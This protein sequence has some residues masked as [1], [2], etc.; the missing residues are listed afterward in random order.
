VAGGSVVAGAGTASPGRAGRAG[1][2]TSNVAVPV[3]SGTTAGA[4]GRPGADAGTGASRSAGNGTALWSGD[5]TS[6]SGRGGASV[7]PSARD[8]SSAAGGGA[9]ARGGIATGVGKAGAEVAGLP[10]L[11]RRLR[12]SDSRDLRRVPGA[13]GGSGCPAAALS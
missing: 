2:H 10:V 7:R 1:D 5:A 13:R 9:A 8:S 6:P 11:V 4:T 12:P 3:I